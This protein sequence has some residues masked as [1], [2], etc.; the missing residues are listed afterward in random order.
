MPLKRAN[1]AWPEQNRAWRQRAIEN[2][3]PRTQEPLRLRAWLASPISWDGWDPLT[4]EGALQSVVVLRETG[5]P[6]DDVYSS[7]PLDLPLSETDIQIPI[8]DSLEYG[9]VPIARA[10]CGRVSSDARSTM[11]WRRSRPRAEYYG[12][13]KVKTTTAEMKAHNL[14]CPTV[15]ATYV[16]FY[17]VGD[18]VQLS[19]LLQDVSHL[20][21]KR[22]GGLGK[23]LSWQVTRSETDWSLFQSDGTLMRVLPSAFVSN[24]GGDLREASLRAPY[25]HPGTRCSAVVP[26][27]GVCTFVGALGASCV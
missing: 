5:L 7:C 24:V 14:P 21:S 17:V 18:E 8:A 2:W 3:A 25:W 13:D 27:T 23:I 6:A 15:T 22:G 4:I 20:G 12:L 19:D 10:S 9:E 11:R 1:S 26:R 16:D